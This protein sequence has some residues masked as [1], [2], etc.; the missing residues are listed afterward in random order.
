[1]EQ[2]GGVKTAVSMALGKWENKERDPETV[3][4]SLGALR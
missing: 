2:E 4:N 3:K 1:M